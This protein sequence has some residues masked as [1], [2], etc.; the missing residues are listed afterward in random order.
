[1]L[2]EDY[3]YVY[4]DDFFCRLSV[5]SHDQYYCVSFGVFFSFTAARETFLSNLEKEN[6]L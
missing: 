2:L 1:M 5:A 4:V 3:W 6:E